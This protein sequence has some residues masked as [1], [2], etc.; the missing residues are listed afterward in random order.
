MK[1]DPRIYLAHKQAIVAS[2]PSLEHL[3][4]EIAGEID[5]SEKIGE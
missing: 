3:E 2:L 4:K 5:E 1:K